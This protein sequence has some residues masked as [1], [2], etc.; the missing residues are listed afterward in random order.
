MKFRE[1]MQTGEGEVIYDFPG[2]WYWAALPFTTDPDYENLKFTNTDDAQEVYKWC[3]LTFGI[4]Q[5]ANH[6]IQRKWR[7]SDATTFHFR[8]QKDRD[9][10]IMRWS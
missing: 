6:K 10:F 8:S 4:P 9:W 1:A 7:R 5:A 2:Y 3:S